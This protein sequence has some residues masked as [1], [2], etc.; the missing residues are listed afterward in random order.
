MIPDFQNA[1]SYE[2]IEQLFLECARTIMLDYE[3]VFGLPEQRRMR[4]TALELYLHSQAWPDP[5]CDRDN[6]Q[7]NQATWYVKRNG[8]DADRSRIDITCG[9]S[10]KNI[11]GGLLIRALD[12]VDGPGKALKQ[13]VRGHVPS[14][15]EWNDEEIEKLNKK[16]SG[17]PIFGGYLSLE[18]P[19]IPINGDVTL[20]QRMNLRNSEG[21]WSAPLRA[22]LST[23]PA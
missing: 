7:L 15:S 9:N 18:P 1:S 17:T 14:S 2:E 11:Y 22:T 10:S 21:R 8:I 12:R 16:I 5:N 13:I 19:Q 4:I 3:L 20:H 6:E 23:G